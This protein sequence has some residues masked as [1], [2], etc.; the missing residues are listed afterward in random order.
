MAARHAHSHPVQVALRGVNVATRALEAK[1]HQVVGPKVVFAVKAVP[2]RGYAIELGH[3]GEL[4][5][6]AVE[7]D[8]GTRLKEGSKLGLGLEHAVAAAQVLD[9]GIAYVGH[10]HCVG[11]GNLGQA[12]H[13]AKVA[14]THLEHSHLVIVAQAEHSERHTQLVVEVSLGLVHAVLLPQHAVGHLLGAGLTHAARDAHHR[15]AKL[16]EIELGNVFHSLQRRLDHDIGVVLIAQ[17]DLRDGGRSALVD[18]LGY[19]LVAVDTLT[20][21]G[22]KEAAAL[23]LAAVGSDGCDLDAFQLIGARVAAAGNGGNVFQC[24]I[25]HRPRPP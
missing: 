1:A 13:L 4:V 24:E 5:V 22:Y 21:D 17:V 19:E 8:V 7:N 18:D 6:V 10:N 14:D 16:L 3:S 25:F 20:L 15:D 12:V 23:N 11:A 2:H 9:V